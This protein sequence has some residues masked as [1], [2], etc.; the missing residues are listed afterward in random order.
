MNKRKGKSKIIEK[1]ITHKMDGIENIV[2]GLNRRNSDKRVHIN[3]IPDLLSRKEVEDLYA[4]DD[5]ARKV[6]EKVPKEGTKKWIELTNID[7][8]M[9]IGFQKELKRLQITKKFEQAWAWARLYGG[10]G[11]YLNIDD[12]ENPETPINFD[13]AK[14]IKSSIILHRYELL[15]ETQ[16]VEKDIDSLNFGMPTLY[17]LQSHNSFNTSL[18]HHERI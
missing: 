3:A 12:G 17:R 10:A 6:I 13:A 14:S 15:A 7:P 4:A 1:P 2:T 9:K 5:I 8:K 16:S 11:I 18:I